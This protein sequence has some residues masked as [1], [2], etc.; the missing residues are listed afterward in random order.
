MT[1]AP[2]RGS[3]S[4]PRTARVS[5]RLVVPA[6]S[7]LLLAAALLT[8]AFVAERQTR[9]LLAAE[10][11]SRLALEAELLARASASP[12]L[13]GFPELTLQ[14]M[15]LEL[16]KGRDDLASAMVLDRDGRV[17]AHP[18][19]R[20]IGTHESLPAGDGEKAGAA[21]IVPGAGTLTAVVPVRHATGA[22]LGHAIVSIPRAPLERALAAARAR[23]WWIAAGLLLVSATLTFALM[24]GLLRPISRLREGLE[25]IGRGDLDTRLA[26]RDRT[27]L[28]MLADTL[29]DMAG[30]LSDAQRAQIEQQ[31]MSAELEAAGRIQASLHL[32]GTLQRGAYEVLGHQRPAAEVGGDYFDAFELVDGRV[33][34]VVADVSGKGLSGCLVTFMLAA[35]VR[36]TRDRLL[37]PREL[38]LEVD[39]NLRPVLERGAFVT[40]WY[41][42]LDPLTGRVT[43]ASAGHLPTVIRRA[44]GRLER[45]ATRGIPLGLLNADV[46]ARGLRDATVQL[47][48][49][50]ALL[51][52]TDGFTEAVLPDG[53]TQ[54]GLERVEE[55][56]TAD[57]A[58][59]GRAIVDELCTRVETWT[60]GAMPDDDQTVLVL[61]RSAAPPAWAGLEDLE[62]ITWIARA[63]A[64]EHHLCVP[65]SL[66]ELERLGSWLD[67]IEALVALP[68]HTRTLLEAALYEVCANIVEHGYANSGTDHV[69]LWWLPGDGAVDGE[70]RGQFAILERGRV[71]D[72]STA[73]PSDLTDRR[74]R[75]KGRGL[76]IAMIRRLMPGIAYRP[77]TPDGNLTLLDF[78]SA[79]MCR[80]YT[81]DAHERIA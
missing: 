56:L 29:D 11:R 73:Q 59:S 30:R 24:S 15:V 51:Q 81:G 20:R 44:D 2:S 58:S 57:P 38:L 42:V 66:P 52:V 76:G 13:E 79:L 41:G 46:L 14:P 7:A 54:F 68:D 70:V 27:E 22:T 19:A 34:M 47:E 71:F 49:G 77:G 32:R 28:G 67:S 31:R 26:L 25:R 78:D 16:L 18:D 69:D 40:V 63:R 4:V 74:A 36:A 10:A 75:L 43:F 61:R 45:H 65:A 80:V 53:V 37:S 72:P 33:G 6:V 48:E 1:P 35:L 9:A 60:E 50:D 12:M 39:R 62:A 3:A 55:V 5:L 17:L 23:Q 21:T 64:S 8:S